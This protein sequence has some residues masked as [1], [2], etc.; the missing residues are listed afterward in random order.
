MGEGWVSCDARRGYLDKDMGLWIK[1]DL[2]SN[3][4]VFMKN[5]LLL[6]LCCDV[7]STHHSEEKH[8]VT[9]CD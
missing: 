2:F 7:L 6:Y 4:D 3:F 5:W 9:S 1:N 8:V